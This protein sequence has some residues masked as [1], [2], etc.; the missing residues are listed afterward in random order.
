MK[1]IRYITFSVLALF[2]VTELQAQQ[3]ETML[4]L[5]Y[6]VSVPTGGFKDIIKDPSFRGWSANILYGAT[7]KLQVGLGVG[8]QDYYQKNP[9]QLYKTTDGSDISAVLTHSIQTIPIL[10]KARYSLGESASVKPYVGLGAG[11]NLVMFR[12]Y[13]GEFGNSESFFRFA[14]QPEAGVFIP[15]KNNIAI[16][17]GAAY[18]Y[19][20]FNKHD[21][22]NLNNVGVYAG[23]KVPL[24]R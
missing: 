6:G 21:I 5:Q 9:R 4:D 14:V 17:V 19:M 3:G 8:F 24:R 1:A 16:T 12:E 7:E 13:L 10:L 18:N 15:V 22:K 23:V 20:P 11:A 2:L